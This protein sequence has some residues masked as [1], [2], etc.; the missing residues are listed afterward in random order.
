MYLNDR[1]KEIKE[2]LLRGGLVVSS[3]NSVKTMALA[4]I[5]AENEAAVAVVS[6]ESQFQALR[7]AL[8][9]C[10]NL[11]DILI[12]ERIIRCQDSGYLKGWSIDSCLRY[13]YVEEFCQTLYRG[14]FRAAVSSYPYPVWV[15]K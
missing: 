8:H 10:S 14:P 6:T 7:D 2:A 11:P 1:I 15:I 13:V 5:L 4:Q 9:Y 12:K 3:R